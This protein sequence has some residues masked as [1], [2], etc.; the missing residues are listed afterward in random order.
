LTDTSHS[1]FGNSWNPFFVISSNRHFF[2]LRP[3]SR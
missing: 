1:D 2:Q 3:V